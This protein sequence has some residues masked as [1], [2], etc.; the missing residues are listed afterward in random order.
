MLVLSMLAYV[1]SVVVS[2]VWNKIPN[3]TVALF[4][5]GIIIFMFGL[6]AEQVASLWFK[7]QNRD[8]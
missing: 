1:A 6:L 7:G 2:G 8:G 4:V 5:G 3:A